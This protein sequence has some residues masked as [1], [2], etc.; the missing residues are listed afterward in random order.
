MYVV[1]SN[2]TFGFGTQTSCRILEIIT[3]FPVYSFSCKSLSLNETGVL[4]SGTGRV[5]LI[6][7]V[8]KKKKKKRM[9]Y[10]AVLTLC[11]MFKVAFEELNVLKISRTIQVFSDP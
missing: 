4:F 8:R 2:V 7:G 9:H 5:K 3:L 6:L 1:A 10:A 11:T